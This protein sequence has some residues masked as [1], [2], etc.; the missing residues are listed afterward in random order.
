M[1]AVH[2]IWDAKHVAAEAPSDLLHSSLTVDTRLSLPNITPH[3]INLCKDVFPKW[4]NLDDSNFS[5]ETIAGGITNLLL[6]VS[7]R[8][9]NG[10]SQCFT[11]RLFGPNT[12]YVINREREL[13]AIK[14]LSA[15]GFG[16]KL[17]G[18][19]GNGMVQSFINARTLTPPDMRDPKLAAEIAK[20][21]NKFHQV[22]IPGS[23]E[24]QLWNDMHKFFEKASA[25]SFD[26]AEKQENT[27]PFLSLK[28]IMK[29]IS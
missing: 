18:V 8:E 22:E 21:L 3:V 4:L 13:Q 14:Y 16:A 20:Q 27:R 5:V 19:F 1:G 28:F 26:D 15:A 23:K 12:D 24:P 2:M 10:D 29:L 9:E 11:V 17:L 7:V 25:L 6:K